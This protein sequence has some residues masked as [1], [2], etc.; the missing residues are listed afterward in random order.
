MLSVQE[1]IADCGLQFKEYP[2]LSRG[3]HWWRHVGSVHRRAWPSSGC[4]PNTLVSLVVRRVDYSSRS[5]HPSDVDP[6]DG[7]A[8][9]G[10][11]VGPGLPVAV[12]R[13]AHVHACLVARWLLVH[14]LHVGHGL[15]ARRVSTNI[16]QCTRIKVIIRVGLYN[17]SKFK[18]LAFSASLH[19]FRYSL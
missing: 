5:T 3:S 12:S 15:A 8:L 14:L 2:P 13:R 6:A 18:V 4:M 1:F 7:D 19:N 16:A 11:V 9:V 10:Y 17:F